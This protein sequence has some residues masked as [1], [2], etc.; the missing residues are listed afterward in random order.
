MVLQLA[1]SVQG[2][3]RGVNEAADTTR[4]QTTIRPAFPG[5]RHGIPYK[6]PLTFSGCERCLDLN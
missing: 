4:E 1:G 6:S 3:P 2:N 5:H